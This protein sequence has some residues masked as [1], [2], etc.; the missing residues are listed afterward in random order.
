M[1]STFGIVV[2]A[3][4]SYTAYDRSKGMFRHD[5][6]SGAVA[7]A[8]VLR[9]L[10]P[11]LGLVAASSWVARRLDGNGYRDLYLTGISMSRF[12]RS[13]TAQVACLLLLIGLAGCLLGVSASGTIWAHPALPLPD[14]KIL[15]FDTSGLT[16]RLALLVAVL[17]LWVLLGSL[18]GYM[19]RRS[20]VATAA[21]LAII[22]SAL[23]L[24]RAATVHPIA[25][26]IHALSPLGASNALVLGQSVPNF[27]RSGAMADVGVLSFGLWMLG[28]V[29][30]LSTRTWTSYL[31][32][33]NPSRTLRIRTL[34][35]VCT[36][37][38]LLIAGFV[39]PTELGERIPWQ[40]KAAWRKSVESRTTPADAVE[41]LLGA[42][43]T[44]DRSLVRVSVRPGNEVA[45]RGLQTALHNVDSSEVVVDNLLSARRPGSV[46][47][48]V[49]TT[50]VTD[51]GELVPPDQFG[52]CLVRDAGN[53]VVLQISSQGLTC[54]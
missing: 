50:A 26:W 23:L 15:E 37:G 22:F 9:V 7:A 25:M 54:T 38:A 2:L 31:T 29:A 34:L 10:L 21:A 5:W 17:V 24:E 20:A 43:A 52:F 13:T 45:L 42:I 35:G 53:W 40:Y 49:G 12:L 16:P 33:G 11:I 18:L 6:A 46:V 44:A 47:V 19:V 48:H 14:G 4:V 51:I 30:L 32:V 27:P 39:V 8:D 28:A 36:S 1:W 3:W 41:E